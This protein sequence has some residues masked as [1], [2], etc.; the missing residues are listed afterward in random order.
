MID[1][2]IHSI[3]SDGTDNI[4]TI[5]SKCEELGLD[6]ISI[7]DH[8]TIAAYSFIKSPYPYTG[9]FISGVE[10]K[11]TFAGVPVEVLGY[12]FDLAMLKDSPCVSVEEKIKIQNK[13]LQ[14]YIRVGNELGI[15]STEGLK[16]TDSRQYAA[17]TYYDDIIKYH[18]NYEVIPELLNNKREDFYRQTSGNINSPFYIDESLDSQPIDFVISEIHR[19]GG[20]AFLAHL[21]QYKGISHI[22][23]LQRLFETTDID[24]CEAYYTTFTEKQTQS[25]LEITNLYKKLIS[26][27]SDYHGKNKKNIELGVG[28]G[29]LNIPD[30]TKDW[31]LIEK[32]IK[33]K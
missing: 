24:G 16:I 20:L 6:A 12:D 2:H 3:C 23:F 26:G 7:T 32:I 9:K 22:D 15:L 4:H 18:H 8:D 19:C 10:I 13:Y 17:T 33:K 1:L 28:Y 29:N 27:G 14:N 21:Y 31:P 25:I 5:L 30:I 11:T